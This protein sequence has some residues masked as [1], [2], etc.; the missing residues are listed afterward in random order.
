METR[1]QPYEGGI[2]HLDNTALND[3][4]FTCCNWFKFS[5]QSINIWRLFRMKPQMFNAAFLFLKI[6]DII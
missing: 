6:I 3:V 2:G 1:V 5:A 4:R